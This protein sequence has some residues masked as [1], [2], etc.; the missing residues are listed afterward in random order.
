MNA[1]A[2]EFAALAAPPEK[3]ERPALARWLWERGID[4]PTA[5]A[6][7]GGVT[8]QSVWSW[9]LPFGDPSRV[10]PRPAQAERVRIYTAGEVPPD[11]FR[12]PA[13]PVP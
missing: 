9:C 2:P 13:E 3:V 7:I 10:E 6:G 1:I 12:P 11:S 5:A 8:R 4:F